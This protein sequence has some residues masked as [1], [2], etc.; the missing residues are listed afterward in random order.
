MSQECSRCAI[1]VVSSKSVTPKEFPNA[2]PLICT[3]TK[4]PN[5][6]PLSNREK[7]NNNTEL[8]YTLNTIISYIPFHIDLD[9][10]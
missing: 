9:T 10:K 5:S 1:V 4:A 2:C 3:Q 8:A 6:L 7:K